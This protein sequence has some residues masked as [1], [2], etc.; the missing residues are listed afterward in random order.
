MLYQLNYR[1]KSGRAGRIRT[2]D[3][4]LPKQM[5]YQAAL[6]PDLAPPAAGAPLGADMPEGKGKYRFCLTGG[7]TGR[8]RRVGSPTPCRAASS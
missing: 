4:L 6:R 7:Q 3:P 8:R 1:R 5:R 2:D